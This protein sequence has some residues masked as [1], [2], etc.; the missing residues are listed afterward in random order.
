M[1]ILIKLYTKRARSAMNKATPAMT[2]YRRH[3]EGIFHFIAN[4]F[5]FQIDKI[6]A[7]QGMKGI[8]EW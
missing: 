1:V 8:R 3:S 4:I 6:S 2:R 5:Y 7:Y